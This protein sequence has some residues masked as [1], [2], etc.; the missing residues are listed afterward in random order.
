MLKKAKQFFLCIFYFRYFIVII[1][2]HDTI[3]NFMVK[4]FLE[5]SIFTQPVNKLL[6]K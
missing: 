6:I 3:I 4:R 1:L 2:F 5:K